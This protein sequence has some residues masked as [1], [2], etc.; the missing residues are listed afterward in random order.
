M[1]HRLL[2]LQ[3]LLLLLIFCGAGIPD[4]EKAGEAVADPLCQ[5]HY[6]ETSVTPST[7]QSDSITV[8]IFLHED[9]IISQYYTL[10]LKEL[11]TEYANPRLQFVGLFPNFSSRPENIKAFGEK[12]QIPFPLKPDYFHQK[13]EALGATVTPEV[14]VVNEKT[15]KTL[16]QGRID[17]TYARVGQRKRVT[18]ITDLKDVLESIRDGQS[19]LIS[20]TQAIGCFIEKNRFD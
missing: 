20:Y 3:G 17:D 11:H 4:S 16:Y 18:T 7:Q 1:N 8:Y 9:C 15:G 14:V 12:Y 13:K 6:C 5:A 10:S 19:I 2:A